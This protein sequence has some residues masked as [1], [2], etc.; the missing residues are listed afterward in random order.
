MKKILTMLLALVMVFSVMCVGASALDLTTGS[1]EGWDSETKTLTLTNAALAEGVT[2]PDGA[3]VIVNGDCSIAAGDA[4]AIESEGA[5]TIVKGEGEGKLALSGANGIMAASVAIEDIDVNFEATTCGIQVYNDAGD[6]KVTLTG[7]DGSIT[8]GYA[9]IYVNGE[10]AETSASVTVDG[11]DLDVTSTAA[12]WNNRARKSGITVYVSTAEKVES[13]ITIANSTV[14]AT[15]F[16]A[17][18]AINNYLNDEDA[19]NS[20]SSRINRC[21]QRHQRYLVRHLC[22]R[23]GTSSRC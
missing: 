14:N 20:A 12:S 16:D 13:S 5:V 10:R 2:L 1:Y 9:G 22:Q 18:L 6:A 15:G 3:T 8:G 21:C 19:T 7:V 11:C 17:G 4:N 23:S